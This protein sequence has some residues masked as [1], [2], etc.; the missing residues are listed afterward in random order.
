MIWKSVRMNTNGEKNAMK[1]N[2]R[3]LNLEAKN[4]ISLMTDYY[5]HHNVTVVV[6]SS[7]ILTTQLSSQF[8]SLL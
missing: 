4:L 3:I 6:V 7:S 1:P 2:L 5:H 8:P